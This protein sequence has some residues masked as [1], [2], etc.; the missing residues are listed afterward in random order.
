MRIRDDDGGSDIEVS[1]LGDDDDECN[2][3][4]FDGFERGE[5][6]GKAAET[7]S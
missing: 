5:G 7:E 1:E 4:S 3:N 6:D 2:G